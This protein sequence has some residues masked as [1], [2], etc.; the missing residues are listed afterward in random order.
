MA[1]A[2]SLHAK[3]SFIG[4][5]VDYVADEGS[6][7]FSIDGEAIFKRPSGKLLVGNTEY[8]CDRGIVIRTSI[9]STIT[10]HSCVMS[11]AMFLKL[12]TEQAQRGPS[13]SKAISVLEQDI[14]IDGNL[15]PM[16][17]IGSNDTNSEQMTMSV[18]P[19]TYSGKDGN[20][21][22]TLEYMSSLPIEK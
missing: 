2:G 10:E 4:N 18:Y 3:F 16:I 5:Y 21:Q 20:E 13:Y 22:V 14:W 1:F 6:Q 11:R 15:P 17:A 12:L 19:Q 8:A 9:Y 7:A